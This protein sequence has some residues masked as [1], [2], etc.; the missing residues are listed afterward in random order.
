M[1]ELPAVGCTHLK[2]KLSWQII[3]SNSIETQVGVFSFG[4]NHKKWQFNIGLDK[5]IFLV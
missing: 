2:T 4:L 5:Q 3:K 1:F